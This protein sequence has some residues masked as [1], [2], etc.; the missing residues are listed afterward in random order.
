[1]MGAINK[2]KRYPKEDVITHTEGVVTASFD[3]TSGGKAV[4]IHVDKSSGDYYLDHMTLLM[5]ERATLPVKT[6]EFQSVTYFVIAEK[7]ELGP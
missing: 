4:N 7:Y 5:I 6:C 3:Y 1:M 2:E